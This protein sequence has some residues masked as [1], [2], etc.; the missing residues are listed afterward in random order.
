M[1][2][3]TT[4]GIDNDFTA[5]QATVAHGATNYKLAGWVNMEFGIFIN[6]FRW[7]HRF[8]D[9]LH[10]RFLDVFKTIFFGM[11]SGQ[12]DSVDTHGLAV[13]INEG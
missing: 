12:D 8:H 2:G 6:P 5:S 11:L 4:I 9:V 13:F 3:H 7:Q 1:A 10:D